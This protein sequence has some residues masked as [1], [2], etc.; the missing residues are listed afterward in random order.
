[1]AG[2]RPHVSENLIRDEAT[3]ALVRR[4]KHGPIQSRVHERIRFTCLITP[5]ISCNDK[6]TFAVKDKNLV[7]LPI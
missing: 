4:L 6:S 1:M 7:L 2:D 3:T 5:S